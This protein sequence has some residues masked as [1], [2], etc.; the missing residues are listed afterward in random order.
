[1]T[2]ARRRLS[3]HAAAVGGAQDADGMTA[4]ERQ[5]MLFADLP[6]PSAP[7]EAPRA[8]ARRRRAS[9]V[10]NRRRRSK[11]LLLDFWARDFNG[12]HGDIP[13]DDEDTAW[14]FPE[15][16]RVMAGHEP[17]PATKG[18]ASIWALAA[19]VRAEPRRKRRAA[20]EAEAKAPTYRVERELGRVRV[21]RLRPDETEEWAERE[22]QRRAK[23]RPPKPKLAAKTRGKKVRAWDGEAVED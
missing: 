4:D 11:Q 22:R 2:I 19:A 15:H 5:P 13:L 21:V 23:Q 8:R 18:A 14:D 10:S 3:D 6:I 9:P 20:P 7:P 16:H 17:P 12:A 1:M